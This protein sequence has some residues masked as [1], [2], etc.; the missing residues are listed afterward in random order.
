MTADRSSSALL[1]TLFV[2]A[3]MASSVHAIQ[4]LGGDP[5]CDGISMC[6]IENIDP[7]TNPVSDETY[8]IV[9]RD[10]EHLEIFDDDGFS[11]TVFFGIGSPVTNQNDLTVNTDFAFSDMNGNPI[12]PDIGGFSSPLAPGEGVG[13]PIQQ[14]SA[15]QGGS[16][17]LHDFEIFLT[18]DGCSTT[19]ILNTSDINSIRIS[20]ID[21]MS[22]VGVWVPEPSAMALWAVVGILL[23]GIRHR[24]PLRPR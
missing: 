12:G 15:P 10:M 14:V 9:L 16:F 13:N 20:G 4:I 18:C 3:S 23:P 5:T 17:I 11:V 19:D 21:S 6:T 7:V 1:L 22:R 24:R 2:L 8:E